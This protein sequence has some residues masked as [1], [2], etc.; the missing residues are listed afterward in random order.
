MW[1]AYTEAGG[2]VFLLTLPASAGSLAIRCLS[3]S[4]SRSSAGSAGGTSSATSYGDERLALS[5]ST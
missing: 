1:E 2:G 3:C 4:T 5:A